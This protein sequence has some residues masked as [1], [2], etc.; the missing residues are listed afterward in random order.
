MKNSWREDETNDLLKFLNDMCE[1]C[2]LPAQNY[3]R[4]QIDDDHEG[5]VDKSS[6]KITSIDLIY[7]VIVIFIE[8]VD[9]LGDYVFSDFRTYK[10]IPNILDTIIEFI[11]GPNIENQKMMGNWKKFISTLNTLMDQKEMGNY[12]G[13]HPEAKAQL[14]ILYSTTQVLLAVCDIKDEKVAN[15][16]HTNVLNQIDVK[17]MIKKMVDIFQYKIGGNDAKRRVYDFN[18]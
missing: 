18:I 3:I 6:G 1:N 14:A 7:Q 9:S 13:I 12:S 17:N 11:Y 16:V 15:R 5:L 10:F 2:F 8:V 4:K